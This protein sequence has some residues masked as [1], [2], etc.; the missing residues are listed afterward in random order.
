M[1]YQSTTRNCRSRPVR[2]DP[3]SAVSRPAARSVTELRRLVSCKLQQLPA[4][5]C[6]PDVV[7][8]LQR[9][10]K[11]S[12]LVYAL[13]TRVKPLP[14]R[15]PPLNETRRA[16]PPPPI[17]LHNSSSAPL[18]AWTGHGGEWEVGFDKTPHI[19]ADLVQ[20]S[21]LSLAPDDVTSRLATARSAAAD[22]KTPAKGAAVSV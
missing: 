8:N 1:P 12:M 10:L 13:D 14:A 21:P 17:L 22:S 18:L 16:E 19:R 15:P 9:A 3:E 11:Q 20:A 5:R 2:S 7:H 4:G 6:D